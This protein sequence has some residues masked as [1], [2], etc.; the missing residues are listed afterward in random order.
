[1]LATEL[2]LGFIFALLAGLIDSSIQQKRFANQGIRQSAINTGIFIL[3]GCLVG[4]FSWLLSRNLS[5]NSTASSALWLGSVLVGGL[6]S[7]SIA[8]IQHLILRS[9]LYHSGYIPWNYA[10]FLNYASERLLLQR[11]GGRY[12]FMHK[13]LQEHFAAMLLQKRP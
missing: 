4:G 8:C 10:R 5:L 3:V 1:M 7:A 6:S 11:V 13:L 12:R 2:T 9:I